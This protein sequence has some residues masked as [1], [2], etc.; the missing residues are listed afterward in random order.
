M[1]IYCNILYIGYMFQHV[2]ISSLFVLLLLFRGAG[3]GGRS[4]FAGVTEI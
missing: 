1:Y 3:G 4:A 2:C